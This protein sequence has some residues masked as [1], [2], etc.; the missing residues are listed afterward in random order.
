[1]EEKM[2]IM[3]TNI[4]PVKWLKFLFI[5]E[6]MSL[7]VS[8]ASVLGVPGTVTDLVSMGL[9]GCVV[10]AMFRL[11]DVNERYRTAFLFGLGQLGGSLGNLLLSGS[12]FTL[13][14]SI[15]S[16]VAAYQQYQGHSE[17][18]EELD[19]K[20]SGRWHRLYIWELLVSALLTVGT[21]GAVFAGVGMDSMLETVIGVV[22]MFAVLP[23]IAL[24]VLY[25]MYLK[26]TMALFREI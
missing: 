11:S 4:V 21:V 15:C 2:E 12:L 9:S 18:T 25:L 23:G 17:I 22:L 5:T 3:D 13:A 14:V 7:A 20:L 19:P 26:K 8:F 24:E 16:L 10:Y 6:I 1:M